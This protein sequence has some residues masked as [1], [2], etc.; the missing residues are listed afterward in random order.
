VRCNHLGFWD[1]SEEQRNLL[2]WT[3]DS[4]CEVAV[5]K[6][7]ER[8]EKVGFQSLTPMGFGVA[9]KRENPIPQI[10]L[11][12]QVEPDTLAQEP[13]L[14]SAGADAVLLRFNSLPHESLDTILEPLA[15]RLWGL[16]VSGVQQ[17]DLRRLE[18]PGCDGRVCQAGGAAA[19]G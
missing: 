5:S 11:V 17:D 2:S 19:G 12:G 15:E 16:G 1:Q 13:G 3:R 14:V 18:E 4:E 9:S 7:I 6:F 8:L 10:M